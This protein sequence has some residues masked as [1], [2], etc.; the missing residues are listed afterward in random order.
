MMP[1]VDYTQ[2]SFQDRRQG[3]AAER[4]NLE[5]RQF[6]DAHSELSQEAR[7]LAMAIDN[8]KRLH[9]RRFITHEEMVAVIKS[10]GYHK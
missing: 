8:Y 4:P 6:A 9:R 3:E 5:R 2:A 10:I 7:E 1:E